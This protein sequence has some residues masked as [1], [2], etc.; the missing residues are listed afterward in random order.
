MNPPTPL[1]ES[2]IE[3]IRL[4]ARQAVWGYVAGLAPV[5]VV[6]ALLVGWLALTLWERANWTDEA[7]AAT[8]REWLDE[9]RNF[10]KTLPELVREYVRMREEAPAG[11]ADPERRLAT[12][13]AEIAEHMRSLAEPTRT[14]QN[15]LPSFPEIYAL[16][17]NNAR[18]ELF[19]DP[20]SGEI[21]AKE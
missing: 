6:W 14:Y 8:V 9:T 3:S 7:D 10:R 16:D 5:G 13:R 21:V 18:T 11:A 19:V 20:T 1:S 2:T 15:Q 4:P 17:P 12:K